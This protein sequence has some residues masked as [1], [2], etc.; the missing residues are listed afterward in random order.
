MALVQKHH[1]QHITSHHY[2]AICDRRRLKMIVNHVLLATTPHSPTQK[3]M[4]SRLNSVILH[5]ICCYI[6]AGCSVDCCVNVNVCREWFCLPAAASLSSTTPKT[7]TMI[8]SNGVWEIS[9][10]SRRV[11]WS[12]C[13]KPSY[14]ARVLVYRRGAVL[15]SSSGHRRDQTRSVGSR[16]IGHPGCIPICQTSFG[17][18]MIESHLDGSRK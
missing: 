14:I 16:T 7:T 1:R 6:V 12:K 15:T 9:I 3:K 18:K 5:R 10:V 8:R 17:N 2:I 4:Q 11:K 13:E